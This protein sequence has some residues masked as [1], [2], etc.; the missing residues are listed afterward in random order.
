MIAAS[1]GSG[2]R[3]SDEPAHS[4]PRAGEVLA[5]AVPGRVK[6]KTRRPCQRATW[7]MMWAAAPNPYRPSSAASPVSRSERYPIRPAHSSG[8]ARRSGYPAG[9]TKQY[10]A[11]A[12]VSSAKPPSIV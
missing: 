8:A 1:T 3:S 4:A 2:G 10:R 7:Q 6:L 11:S 9:T 5:L 12:S